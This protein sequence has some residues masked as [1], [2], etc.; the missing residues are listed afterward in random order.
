MT[1][2]GD[3][4][5]PSSVSPGDAGE[6]APEALVAKVQRALGRIRFEN[7]PK[8]VQATIVV[9]GLGFLIFGTVVSLARLDLSAAEMRWD[10]IIAAAVLGLLLIPLNALEFA[11]S[12]RLAGTNVA[13]GRAVEVTIVASAFNVLPVPAGIA[14][15]IRGLY[16]SGTGTKSA[17][18]ATG[19]MGLTWLSWGLLVGAGALI[20]LDS[21]GFG[22]A[23]LAAGL[24]GLAVAWSLLRPRPGSERFELLGAASILELA[25]LSLAAIR[26]YLVVVGIGVIVAPAQ[27]VVLAVGSVLASTLGVIPGGLGVW[28]GISAALAVLVSLPASVG[29]LAAAILRVMGLIQNSLAAVGLA[30]LRSRTQD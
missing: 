5:R 21:L 20:V 13:F 11:A 2:S 27:A 22:L 30:L 16:R 18:L 23:F 28:E 17:V 24:V 15:R 29:F 9:L 12:G 1:A 10:A 19:L 8:P 3:D 7:Q 26:F 4:P 25:F 6:D 14:V